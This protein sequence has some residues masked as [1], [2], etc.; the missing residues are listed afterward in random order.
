LLATI[1]G[2]ILAGE[3]RMFSKLHEEP[4]LTEVVASIIAIMAIVATIY[5]A[6]FHSSEQAQVA[7]VGLTGAVSSYFLTPKSNGGQKNG[8]QSR[9]T[10]TTTQVKNSEPVSEKLT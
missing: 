4:T 8:D 1:C 7:L 6:V 9:T 2:I 10:A 3:Y 5:A